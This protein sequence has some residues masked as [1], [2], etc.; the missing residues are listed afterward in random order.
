V[1]WRAFRAGNIEPKILLSEMISELILAKSKDANKTF[2]LRLTK[3]Y[4]FFKISYLKNTKK[5]AGRNLGIRTDVHAYKY[6]MRLSSPP[7][8]PLNPYD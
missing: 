2:S 4:S 3:K 1:L 7:Q 6:P 8:M 5:I